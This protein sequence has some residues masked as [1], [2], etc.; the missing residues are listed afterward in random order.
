[1]R[2]DISGLIIVLDATMLARGLELALEAM[3]LGLP[4]IIVLNLCDQLHRRGI[5]IDMAALSEATGVKV[6]PCSALHG[7]GI[8]EAL[9][10][11]VSAA[12]NGH[13]PRAP[14]Y[15]R[16]VES[17]IKAAIAETGSRFKAIKAIECLDEK[18]GFSSDKARKIASELERTR[19]IPSWEIIAAE[20]HH[21]AMKTAEAVVSRL[22]ERPSVSS[23]IDR[24][25]MHPWWG[26][27]TAILI[28]G[29]LFW[30][31]FYLGRWIE[32]ILVDPLEAFF[33]LLS[34]P[35]AG[36]LI[37]AMAS[38]FLEGVV[39]AV[40]IVLPFF[41]PLILLTSI[42]EDLGYLPR[43]AHLVDGLMHRIG[44]HGK[45]VIPFILG[46]GCS[47]PAVAAVRIMES[48]RDRV[49]TGLL[50]PMIPCGARTV[51]ILG[52]VGYFFGGWWALT[53]YVLNIIVIASV[54]TI[55]SRLR[56]DE[57]WGMV[58]EIPPYRLPTLRTVWLNVWL[59]LREFLVV[60]LPALLL[61]SSLLGLLDH[62]NIS[63]YMNTAISPFT[64][65]LLGLP[66]E[67]G[68]PLV[69]GFL[70]KELALIMAAQALSVSPTALN[71]A[72]SPVQMMTYTLFAVFY[73]P[74]LATV[75]ITW[76]ELGWKVALGSGGLSLIV[77][78]FV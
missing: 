23:R 2:G 25:V 28:F 76:R 33:S 70:R 34:A 57:P 15:S 53:V 59:Q 46:Y 35:L 47:V 3:E 36:T 27:L 29:F 38:G 31:I 69:F 8:A 44:L 5:E 55:L 74:C 72:L 20:R 30:I 48:R 39:G 73:V 22:S 67:L 56:K 49:L 24:V 75:V 17:A 60:V 61:G 65:G 64:S 52:L 13:V 7:K 68:A 41:V 12:R 40:G 78:S 43:V 18:L 50:V 6:I 19:G 11:A 63:A 4:M 16:D 45:A 14:E 37:G 26:L 21:L 58:M 77:A 51:I 9:R 62:W 10:E 32:G 71:A 42:M 66:R 1:M 54:G